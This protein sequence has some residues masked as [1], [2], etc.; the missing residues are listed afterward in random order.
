M[1]KKKDKKQSNNEEELV[2]SVEET[3]LEEPMPELTHK[4]YGIAKVNTENGAIYHL[5]EVAYNPLTGDTGPAELVYKDVFEDV[6]DRF[7]MTVAEA[8]L[9]R[10]S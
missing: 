5:V 4:A 8:L 10:T 9:T 1:F 7:K 6:V 2:E 3:T